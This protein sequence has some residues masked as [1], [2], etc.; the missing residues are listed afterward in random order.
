MLSIMKQNN[1]TPK[2]YTKKITNWSA[3][4]RALVCRGNISIYIDE[5]IAKKAFLKPQRTHHVGHPVEYC[6]DLILLILTLRELFRLP[7]R[8]TIGFVTGLLAGMRLSWQLPDYSTLSRRMLR[9]NVDFCQRFRGQ[10]VI[11]LID[12]SGF[13]VFGE[14]EWKV[15]KHGY[16]YRRTWRKTHIAVDF[17]SRDILGVTNTKSNV[18]D[19]TQFAPLFNQAKQHYRASSCKEHCKQHRKCKMHHKTERHHIK[20]IIG[21]GAY[22]SKSNYLLARQEQLELITPPPGN[23]TEHLNMYHYQLY[24]TPGWEERNQTIRQIEEFGLDGWAADTEYHRRSL[25]E[26]AFYRL[27]IIFGSNLKSRTE[28]NQYTEQCIRASLINRF[29]EMGLPRYG[30]YALG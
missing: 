2:L 4:N 1:T 13:K 23:A 12:S 24:D 16:S 7:L 5:A 21:D 28:S 15:R 27:K 17:E 9:L 6:D 19:N 30:G 11:L 26:N 14:G 25:V 8:Q 18:H 10:N 29:N 22:D 3:Y 20:A